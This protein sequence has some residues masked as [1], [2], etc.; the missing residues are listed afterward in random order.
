VIG[1]A[2][3]IN[4]F[5]CTQVR[6]SLYIDRPEITDDSCQTEKTTKKAYRNS[7]QVQ[8]YTMYVN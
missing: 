2:F 8:S 3:Q 7:V 5:M 4:M 6:N 1:L